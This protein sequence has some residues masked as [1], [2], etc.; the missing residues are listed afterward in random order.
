MSVGWRLAGRWLVLME[1]EMV[2]WYAQQKQQTVVGI[3]R[4]RKRGG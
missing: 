3:E 1:M 4:V 2:E